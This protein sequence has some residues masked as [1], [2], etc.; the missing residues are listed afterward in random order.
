MLSERMLRRIPVERLRASEIA[1]AEGFRFS[2]FHR[3]VKRTIDIGVA[4]VGLLLAAPILAVAAIAIKLDSKGPLFYSQDRVGLH[5]R[6]FKITKLRTM[7]VDA[8]A[9]GSPQW[10]KADDPR[11]TRVG[12]L[13]RKTRVDEIPQ[14]LA[15]LLGDMS[16]VGP[17]PERPYFVEQLEQLIPWFGARE[18]VPPG[19]TGWAQI[20]YPYGASIED[21]KAKLEYDLYYIKNGSAFLDLA[22]LFH[23]VRHV[24]MGRGA[25]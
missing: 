12:R 13:L 5:G 22:I 17:R 4:G 1:F 11:V 6:L 20:R 10:A 16:L 9:G 14:L 3:F 8:E 7:R 18:A 21:A 25:R 23:T 24:L 15:V 19:V 2:A